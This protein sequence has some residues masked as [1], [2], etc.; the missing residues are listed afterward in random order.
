MRGKQPCALAVVAAALAL[1]LPQVAPGQGARDAERDEETRAEGVEGPSAD[2]TPDD[3]GVQIMMETSRQAQEELT[4]DR[5]AAKAAHE[6]KIDKQ[7]EQKEK[8]RE[9]QEAERSEAWSNIVVQGAGA[10]VAVEG[11]GVGAAGSEEDEE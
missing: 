3:L 6:M 1:L 7:R 11:A 2:P 4:A 9:Q 8:T 5:E 10:A